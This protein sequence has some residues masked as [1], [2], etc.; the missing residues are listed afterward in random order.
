MKKTCTKCLI[1]KPLD[2]FY[3]R[4]R[5]KDGLSSRCKI[6]T[7]GDV[8]QYY[9]ENSEKATAQ[10]R[11]YNAANRDKI[12]ER[13]RAARKANPEK[14]REHWRKWYK[15]NPH[16]AHSH[17]AKRKAVKLKATPSWANDEAIKQYYLI[18]KFLTFELQVDFEV[19]HIVPLQSDSVCGLHWEGNLSVML[20]SINAAKNNRAWPDMP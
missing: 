16:I 5:S 10:K 9:A 1:E 3:K 19:D 11:E 12:A 4:I 2:E 20:G 13:K 8:R 17:T 14:E 15:S 18:A 6:C 7:K